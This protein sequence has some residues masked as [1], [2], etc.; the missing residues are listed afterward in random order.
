[1]EQTLLKEDK[2]CW[3]L[4]VKEKKLCLSISLQ[5]VQLVNVTQLFLPK[6]VKY[7]HYYHDILLESTN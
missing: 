2:P 6:S 1:M 4:K 3:C 5:S 7:Y